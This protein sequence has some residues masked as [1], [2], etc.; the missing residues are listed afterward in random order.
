MRDYNPELLE[1]QLQK[2]LPYRYQW[3]RKQ[4]NK[5]DAFTSFIYDTPIWEDFINKLKAT[6][7]ILNVEKGSF[8]DYAANR[9]FNF[10]SAMAVETIFNKHTLVTKVRNYRDSEKD[11]FIE[12]I[13]FDH[14]TSVFPKGFK[15]TISYAKANEHKLIQWFYENQSSQQRFHLK[16]RLFVVVYNA[17]GEH[18]KIK[19]D[20]SLLTNEINTFLN[21]Y[22][23]EKLHRVKISENQV[24]CSAI[25][26]VE[27]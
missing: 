2:R 5:W 9:W 19:A 22:S 15:H 11:F 16:N 6:A 21:N 10:W 27:K 23:K 25:I 7:E 26:W 24:V 20:I 13:P 14:K 17:T 12:N 4:T 8:F 3:G 1:I 18:W